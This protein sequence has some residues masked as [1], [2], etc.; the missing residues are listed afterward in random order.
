MDFED[1]A[2]VTSDD[3]VVS[4]DEGNF[5]L[6]IDPKVGASADMGIGCC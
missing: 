4:Y 5:S 3:M 6:V 1:A 2:K